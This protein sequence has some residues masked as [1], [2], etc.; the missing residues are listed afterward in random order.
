MN[1]KFRKIRMV[2]YRVSRYFFA[3]LV[4]DE[5]LSMAHHYARRIPARFARDRE[6]E[7]VSGGVCRNEY[8]LCLC[9]CVCV[10][11]CVCVYLSTR[12]AELGF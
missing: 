12:A 6:R 1:I 5:M 2:T 11:L 4:V 9:V 8:L 3:I 7:R 10:C